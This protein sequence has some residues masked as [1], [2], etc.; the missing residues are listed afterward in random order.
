MAENEDRGRLRGG[1]DSRANSPDYWDPDNEYP[2]DPSELGTP[3][4]NWGGGLEDRTGCLLQ[5][6]LIATIGLGAGATGAGY[7]IYEVARYLLS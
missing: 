1:S 3:R 4:E 7:L 5:S 6:C 2:G